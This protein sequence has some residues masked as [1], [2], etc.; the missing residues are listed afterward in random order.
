MQVLSAGPQDT[1]AVLTVSSRTALPTGTGPYQ[2]GY[3]YE[4]LTFSTKSYKTTMKI[5]YPAL[6]NESNATTDTSKGPYPTIVWLPGTCCGPENYADILINM[7]SWGL[8]VVTM[9]LDNEDYSHSGNRT[10]VNE[11]LDHL[12]YENMT[13]TEFFYEM[14]D[15]EAF[16]LAGHSSGGGLALIDAYYVAR[17]K[18]I[19]V[20]SPAIANS[21]IDSLSAGWHLPVMCQ[22]GTNDIY[23]I[24]YCRHSFDKL[25]ALNSK[26]EMIGGDH[27]GPFRNELIVA[28]FL[29]H[30][31]GVKDYWTY[32]YGEGAVRG[33]MAGN[34]DVWFKVTDKI[35]FPPHLER[36]PVDMQ[37]DMMDTSLSFLGSIEGFY[38]PADPQSR[39]TWDFDGDGHDEYTNSTEINT[40]YVFREPGNYTPV[41]SYRLGR[42]SVPYDNPSPILTIHNYVPKADAGPDGSVV[43]GSP[44]IFNA[45]GTWDSESDYSTLKY[46]WDFGDGAGQDFEP[47]D[48]GMVVGHAYEGPGIY[49]VVLWVIDQHGAMNLNNTSI[50]VED[51][52]PDIN[53]GPDR[54]ALEDEQVYFYADATDTNID[55]DKLQFRWDFGDGSE[56]TTWSMD[57]RAEHT[58]V[59]KG[60]FTVTASVKDDSS[61]IAADSVFVTVANVV[62]APAILSP[63]TGMWL[64]MDKYIEFDATAWDTASDAQNLEYKWDFGDGAGTNFSNSPVASHCYRWAGPTTVT[65]YVRDDEGATNFTMEKII[66]ENVPP[67]I[68]SVVPVYDQSIIE[69]QALHFSGTATDTSSDR[70]SLKMSWTIEG[71]EYLGSSIDH[72]FTKRGAFEARFT[73]KDRYGA[74]AEKA[75]GIMVEN[76]QPM[77]TARVEPQVALVG[78]QVNFTSFVDDTPSDLRVIHVEWIF[79]DGATGNSLNETHTY[80][81]VGNY[82]VRVVVQDD[83]NDSDEA[84]FT[85][86][87]QQ[88]YVPPVP[89]KETQRDPLV[90]EILIFALSACGLLLLGSAF[91]KREGPPTVTQ[92]GPKD[93]KKARSGKKGKKTSH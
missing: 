76:V 19:Q 87:V 71:V 1:P 63:G 68:T 54:S 51:V 29:M 74:V 57:P 58:F 41:L 93:K 31:G 60:N 59:S 47:A 26:V 20:L 38:L 79:G 50:K 6:T 35:F 28:F 21:T 64:D 16:G 9:G 61:N 77:V 78:Q 4:N 66:L 84:S 65:L 62:P 92:K 88:P 80:S 82:L 91:V 14:M 2:V 75:I 49:S 45:S 13:S 10:D 53:V 5:Y 72:T 43:E 25:P 44:Y 70:S 73:V 39:F 7:A 52:S 11:L 83:N 36:I 15:K 12:E 37:S 46:K 23:Y 3:H 42:I 48:L 32:F 56:P 69:D 55:M 67:V 27:F 24:D 33:S 18:A 30:L 40:S 86:M 17:I 90:V 34:Y 89:S 8:V 22:A 81:K 85:V